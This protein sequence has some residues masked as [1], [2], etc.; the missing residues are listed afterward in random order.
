MNLHVNFK[1]ETVFHRKNNIF[2]T[3]KIKEVQDIVNKESIE[4]V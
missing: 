3:Y 4:Q 1:N 2:G